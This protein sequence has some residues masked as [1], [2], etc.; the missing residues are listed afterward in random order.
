MKTTLDTPKSNPQ[1][2]NTFHDSSLIRNNV[3]RFMAEY[4]DLIKHMPFC[5]N[6]S[7]E[8]ELK[9]E[10]TRKVILL[11][12]SNYDLNID[13]IHET[14]N[15][16]VEIIDYKNDKVIILD[17]AYPSESKARLAGKKYIFNLVADHYFI[18]KNHLL[19]KIDMWFDMSQPSGT[20]RSKED[21]YPK[22][23]FLPADLEAEISAAQPVFGRQHMIKKP[24]HYN[25]DDGSE[26]TQEENIYNNLPE[27]DYPGALDHAVV[28][29][30]TPEE[31]YELIMDDELHLAD[32]DD[33]FGKIKSQPKKYKEIYLMHNTKEYPLTACAQRLS[34]SEANAWKRYE[35]ATKA[36]EEEIS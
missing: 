11:S 6:E 31:L 19:D 17:D 25:C 14:S 16:S 5:D 24:I 20:H 1:D 8:D 7:L 26:T 18:L 36:I 13:P 33:R 27:T 15:F 23:D 3:I 34:I 12:K 9:Q 35:R 21:G 10:A 4:R 29:E 28:E 2:N 30:R 22:Y 32:L